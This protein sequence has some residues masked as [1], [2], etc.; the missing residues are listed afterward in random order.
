MFAIGKKKVL[1]MHNSLIYAPLENEVWEKSKEFQG[2]G[3]I[4]VI[5]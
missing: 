4:V 3:S 1:G 5:Y 2:G